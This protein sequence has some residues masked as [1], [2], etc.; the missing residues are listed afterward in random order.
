MRRTC[1]ARRKALEHPPPIVGEM[2]L[3][4]AVAEDHVGVAAPRPHGG[5][6]ESARRPEHRFERGRD[7]S[8][9]ELAGRLKRARP[10]ASRRRVGLEAGKNLRTHVSL[11]LHRARIAR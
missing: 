9:R 4:D 3:E 6:G 7:G 2:K 5:G 10:S 11:A 1:E 8:E